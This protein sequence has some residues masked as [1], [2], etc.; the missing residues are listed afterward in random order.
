[1]GRRLAVAGRPARTHPAGKARRAGAGRGSVRR[2]PQRSSVQ[3]RAAVAALRSRAQSAAAWYG[4]GAGTG[5]RRGERLRAGAVARGS[6]PPCVVVARSWLPPLVRCQ[7][8]TAS[9]SAA[10][11]EPERV[12]GHR[13]RHGVTPRCSRTVREALRACEVQGAGRLGEPEGGS[14]PGFPGG[15]PRKQCCEA[16]PRAC[17]RCRSSYRRPR[18]R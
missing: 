1:V 14:P 12:A 10:G 8:R 11:V 6:R 3:A 17:N 16:F 9:A 13:D 4:S 2:S 7:R 15:L 5:R 18:C